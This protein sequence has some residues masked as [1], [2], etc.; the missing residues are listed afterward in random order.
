MKKLAMALVFTTL[1]GAGSV[2]ASAR[3]NANSA[4][5]ANAP[6]PGRHHRRHRRHH[7]RMR[8]HHRRAANTNS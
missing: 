4:P 6:A 5:S 3:Q 8:R 1:V 2:F 7:R